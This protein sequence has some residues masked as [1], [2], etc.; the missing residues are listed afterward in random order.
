M[1]F[2][3]IC[4]SAMYNESLNYS[5]NYIKKADVNFSGEVKVTEEA[6]N[7]VVSEKEANIVDLYGE[8]IMDSVGSPE[9]GFMFDTLV[10]SPHIIPYSY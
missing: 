5:G 4:V 7:V 1:V 10:P 9:E 8:L 3:V 2:I 6:R